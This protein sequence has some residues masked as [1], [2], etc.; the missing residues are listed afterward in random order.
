MNKMLLLL[1][2]IWGRGVLGWS[3]EDG[4]EVLEK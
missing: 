4:G 2:W 3:I 1:G